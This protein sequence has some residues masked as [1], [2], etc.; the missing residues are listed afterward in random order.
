MTMLPSTL[1]LV[2]V[3]TL[4]F[5]YDIV[6]YNSI[7]LFCLVLCADGSWLEVRVSCIFFVCFCSYDCYVDT[8]QQRQIDGK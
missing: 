1:W 5:H 3:L 8:T 7:I 2:L 4:T 6:F